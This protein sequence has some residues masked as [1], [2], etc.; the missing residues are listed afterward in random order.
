MCCVLLRL[1][2]LL[3]LHFAADATQIRESSND[4]FIT[5]NAGGLNLNDRVSK[6]EAHNNH[7]DQEIGNLKNT[8]VEERKVS[9]QLRGRVAKLEESNDNLKIIERHKRPYR[10]LPPHIAR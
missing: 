3:F 8:I 10:L 1:P 9:H 7:Q 2:L 6:L 4:E 5:R